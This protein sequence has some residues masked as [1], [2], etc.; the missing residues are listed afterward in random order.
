MITIEDTYEEF[1]KELKMKKRQDREPDGILR[2]MEMNVIEERTEES[3]SCS[4]SIRATQIGTDEKKKYHDLSK[5][6][7]SA[8]LT[9]SVSSQP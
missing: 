8:C 9:N 2:E 5:H 3:E 4:Q 1:E 6:T 7:P